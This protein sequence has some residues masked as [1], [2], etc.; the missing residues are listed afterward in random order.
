[1]LRSGYNSHVTGRWTD[2]AASRAN[3]IDV[4]ASPEKFRAFQALAFDGQVF[5]NF[6]TLVET[7]GMSRNPQAVVA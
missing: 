3:E 7:F 5:G 4:V 1:M 2:G 6:P